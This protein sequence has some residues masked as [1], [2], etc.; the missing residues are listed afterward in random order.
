M[1]PEIEPTDSLQDRIPVRSSKFGL[2]ITQNRL[3][4]MLHCLGCDRVQKKSV[5]IV[6]PMYVN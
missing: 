5:M 6:H 2:G 3:H 1:M 4:S